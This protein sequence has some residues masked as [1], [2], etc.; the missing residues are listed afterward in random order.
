MPLADAKC[1][2]AQPGPRP[3]KLTDGGGLQLWLQP[4]G[5]RLWRLAYRFDGKQKLL[6]L[7]VY[8][9]VSLA[10][11]RQAR[12][13]AR[14]LL[15]EGPDPTLEKKRQAQAQAEAP[16]FRGVAEE[17]ATKLRREQRSEATMGKDRMAPGLCQRGVWR[18]TNWSDLGSRHF[19][20]AAVS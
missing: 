12:E 19:G 5:A 1:R 17:Y 16:T 8:P 2:S 20:R 3:Q 10:R 6:A 7:G 15:A 14:R 13:D 9:A 4:T 18:R 11:A